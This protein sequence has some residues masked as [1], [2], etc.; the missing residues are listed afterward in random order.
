[1]TE[2]PI[3]TGKESMESPDVKITSAIAIPT[4]SNLETP[5]I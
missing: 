1:M 4:E 5:P 3:E 2:T